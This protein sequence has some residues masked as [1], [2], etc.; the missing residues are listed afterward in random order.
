MRRLMIVI[1]TA[2]MLPALAAAQSDRPYTGYGYFFIAPGA[3]TPGNWGTLH[4]GG[5]GQGFVYK[6]LGV[7]A[8]LGFLGPRECLGEGFG[9]LSVNGAY[10]FRRDK[11]LVPFVTSGYSLGF[12][13]GIAHMMNV[14]GGVQYWFKPRVGL[15]LEFRDHATVTGWANGGHLYGF[16]MGIALR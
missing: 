2:V 7:G 14:G 5:G 15:Y 1:A 12:R 8:E 9:V 4:I 11:K 16:R 13:S 10:H 3:G 6:G